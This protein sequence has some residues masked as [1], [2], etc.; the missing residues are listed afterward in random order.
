[1][2]GHTI[3]SCLPTLAFRPAPVQI[4]GLGYSITTGAN[5]VDY[6]L[7]ERRFMPP[8]L[9]AHNREASVNMQHSFMIAPRAALL[10]E[11][12]GL[13]PNAV[14][15]ANFSHPC[16]I[17]PDAF[18]AWM[19]ILP[20]VPNAVLWMGAF[21]EGTVKNLS[22]EAAKHGVDPARLIFSPPAPR[23]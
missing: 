15:F 7:T 3:G 21:F 5:F 19:R 20:A 23:E 6:L 1:M 8:E 2:S 16:K 10:C 11:A 14:V 12:V 17:E 13:P 9:A 18:G 22:H 4:H